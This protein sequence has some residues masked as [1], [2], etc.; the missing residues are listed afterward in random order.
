MKYR[1]YVV[2]KDP[3]FK[4]AV[5]SELV[6]NYGSEFIPS[7]RIVADDPMHQSEY[8]GV[9]LLTKEE[10]DQIRQDPRVLDV[11]RDPVLSTYP[12]DSQDTFI[13]SLINNLL[14]QID[15]QL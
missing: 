4:V 6:S 10:A 14:S 12:I 9:Y 3:Q 15:P 1:Y 8:N 7:R 13:Y 5:H 11:E 2:V